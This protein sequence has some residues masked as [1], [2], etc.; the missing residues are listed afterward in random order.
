MAGLVPKFLSEGKEETDARGGGQGLLPELFLLLL[1]EDVRGR[2]CDECEKRLQRKKCKRKKVGSNFIKWSTPQSGK[3]P[4]VVRVWSSSFF[5]GLAQFFFG[6]LNQLNS[7]SKSWEK[8]SPQ[9]SVT[10][11]NFPAETSDRS[12]TAHL[13]N[14]WIGLSIL[15]WFFRHCSCWF[16]L[17]RNLN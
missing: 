13:K 3:P 9:V 5:R 16:T 7:P 1:G 4:V 12:K 14:K 15:F 11:L 8:I 17:K 6:N 2:I 10:Y